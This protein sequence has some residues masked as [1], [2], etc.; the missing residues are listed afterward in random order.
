M[1]MMNCDMLQSAT[2]VCVRK[3]DGVA[4]R[5]GDKYRCTFWHNGSIRKLTRGFLSYEHAYQWLRQKG[6]SVI[7][8]ERIGGDEMAK[9]ARLRSDYSPKTVL[10]MVLTD[11][12][13]VCMRI[14]GDGEMRIATSGSQLKGEDHLRVLDALKTLIDAVE[15]AEK[16]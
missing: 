16:G 8:V 3:R 11:D 7:D 9:I 10:T 14:F 12:G 4:M 1:I 13:D 6:Y 5:R 2:T 15:S